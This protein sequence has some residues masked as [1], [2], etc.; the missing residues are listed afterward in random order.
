MDK[1]HKDPDVID[2][3]APRRA[4]YLHKAWKKHQNTVYWVDI[5]LA[6]EKGL[7]F[8]QTR[9]NAIIRQETLPAY[10]V[11]NVVRLK[12]GDVLYDKVFMSPRPPP[13]ISL[14]LEWKRELGSENAQRSEV[15]QLSRSFQS[16]QPIQ[17]PSRERTERPVVKDDTR[18]VQDGTKTSRSQVID[19]N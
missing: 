14:K 8:Y 9:S 19:V 13:K 10:C 12:T 7:T 11:P 4:Q 15:G 16:K 2:L 5:D 1:N 6:I 17:S 3:S 18:T